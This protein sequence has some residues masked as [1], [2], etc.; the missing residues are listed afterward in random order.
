ML[1]KGED[2][3]PIPGIKSPL[4]LE[5]NLAAADVE[6]SGE[7]SETLDAALPV[8]RG[9]GHPLRGERHGAAQPLTVH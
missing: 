2:I 7:D 1:A 5:E 6:L 3:V 9:G 8:G 4:R